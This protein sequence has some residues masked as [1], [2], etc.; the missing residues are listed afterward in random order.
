MGT[1][2]G[3]LHADLDWLADRPVGPNVE[4]FKPFLTERRYAPNTAASYVAGVAR[5]ARWARSIRLRRQR[6]DEGSIAE[7]LDDHLPSCG[8]AGPTRHD[9]DGFRRR[10]GFDHCCRSCQTLSASSARPPTPRRCSK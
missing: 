4:A 10:I 5:F 3:F 9:R 2:H 1:V 7:F 6:I 8:C